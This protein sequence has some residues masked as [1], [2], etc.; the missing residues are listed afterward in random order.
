MIEKSGAVGK[1]DDPLSF[2]GSWRKAGVKLLQDPARSAT[3]LASLVR[4]SAS[5][6]MAWQIPDD[7][8]AQFLRRSTIISTVVALELMPHTRH[9]WPTVDLKT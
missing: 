7:Y 8:A 3:N 9:S 2:S 6:P 4:L 1:Y 5:C